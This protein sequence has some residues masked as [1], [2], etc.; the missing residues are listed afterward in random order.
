MTHSQPPPGYRPC[1]L[2]LSPETIRGEAVPDRLIENRIGEVSYT[3]VPGSTVTICTVTLDTGYSVWGACA[4]ACPAT[5]DPEL[6]KQCSYTE[7]LRKLKLLFGFLATEC[8]YL[9]TA[10]TTH[11]RGGEG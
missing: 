9:Y 1:D 8:K 2:A 5:F 10:N 3:V 6:G 11:L 7:A 4:C